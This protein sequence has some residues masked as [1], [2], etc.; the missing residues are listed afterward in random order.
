SWS[1]KMCLISDMPH[2][3][4]RSE[5]AIRNEIA[6]TIL[7][8]QRLQNSGRAS[9]NDLARAATATRNTNPRTQ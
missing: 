1:V 4:C 6:Q 5:Q 3:V 8:Y 7:A 9:H 2:W